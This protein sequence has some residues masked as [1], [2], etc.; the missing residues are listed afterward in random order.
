MWNGNNKVDLSRKREM[1]GFED[2]RYWVYPDGRAVGRST[3]FQEYGQTVRRFGEQSAVNNLTQVNTLELKLPRLQY[4]VQ[5]ILVVFLECMYDHFS[6]HFFGQ[7]AEENAAHFGVV[8]EDL[9]TLYTGLFRRASSVLHD[10]ATKEGCLLGPHSGVID[11]CKMIIYLFVCILTS[12]E[13]KRST[14]SFNNY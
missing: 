11:Q 13:L 12:K 3:M 4:L 8:F 10:Q 1:G 7:T 9:Q 14:Q 5:Q 2:S 6:S